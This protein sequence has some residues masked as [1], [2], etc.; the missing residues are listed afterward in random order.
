[1]IAFIE[2]SQVEALNELC[3]YGGGVMKDADLPI[4]EVGEVNFCTI[5]LI[6]DSTI[7]LSV[8][9]TPACFLHLFTVHAD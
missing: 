7:T 2:T 3:N 9:K 4:T 6:T 8:Q 1:M 5:A